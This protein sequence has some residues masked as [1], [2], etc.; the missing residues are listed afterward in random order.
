MKDDPEL[1]TR[2]VAEDML[3]FLAGETLLR[4]SQRDESKG[5]ELLRAASSAQSHESGGELLRGADAPPSPAA[6]KPGFL[7]RFRQASAGIRTKAA[8]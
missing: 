6:G 7:Q 3:R 5:E 8:N 2:E 1:Q 4:P